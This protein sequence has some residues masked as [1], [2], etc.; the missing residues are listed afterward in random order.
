MH[1]TE[2]VSYGTIYFP[3]A[4]LI[5]AAFWWEKPITL[6]LSI[7]IMTFSDTIAAIIGERTVN[8]R[9]FKIWKDTKSI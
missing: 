5:L 3:F 7:L 9:Q 1:S 4:F 6:V 8:S 2:R